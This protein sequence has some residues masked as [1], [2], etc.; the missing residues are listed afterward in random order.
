MM[1]KMNKCVQINTIMIEPLKKALERV[2]NRKIQSTWPYDD[3]ATVIA[4][5]DIS[6]CSVALRYDRG[7]SGYNL[8]GEWVERDPAWWLWVCTGVY[9]QYLSGAFQYRY[10]FHSICDYCGKTRPTL[11]HI[12]C[13]QHAINTYR[14]LL[15]MNKYNE[16]GFELSRH[17]RTSQQALKMKPVSNP[18]V[19][20]LWIMLIFKCRLIRARSVL[21]N[22]HALRTEQL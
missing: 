3:R 2:S 18:M 4:N 13:K 20:H 22:V 5:F 14:G 10:Y 17:E 7:F 1:M 11:L 9:W 12:C 19:I 6:V 16:R 8:R 15:R 21:A